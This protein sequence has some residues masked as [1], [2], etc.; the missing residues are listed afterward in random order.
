MAREGG[1]DALCMFDE[2]YGVQRRVV[3]IICTKM[4]V[5]EDGREGSSLIILSGVYPL[6]GALSVS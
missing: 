2:C 1:S 6:S 3:A 5:V 4:R